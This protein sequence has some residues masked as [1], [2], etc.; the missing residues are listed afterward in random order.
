MEKE[1]QSTRQQDTNKMKEESRE[2]FAQ[3]DIEVPPVPRDKT[4]RGFNHLGTAR[5]LCPPVY[6]WE[7]GSNDPGYVSDVLSRLLT[8]WSSFLEKI[9]SGG[10]EIT[11]DQF[12][13]FLYDE[14]NTDQPLEEEEWDVGYGLLRSS[15]CFWVRRSVSWS[16]FELISKYTVLQM[17]FHGQ[18]V[19]I[20]FGEEKEV[21]SQ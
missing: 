2:F 14:R 18:Q 8:L 11:A 19:P 6:I 10:F 5:A 17:Y 4:G 15:L 21:R 12:P 3:D 9:T 13:N 20:A 1:S 16:C 7:F